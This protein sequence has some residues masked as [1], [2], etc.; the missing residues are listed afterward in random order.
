MY[1]ASCRY[2]ESTRGLR[3]SIRFA[4]SWTKEWLNSPLKLA[5][6]HVHASVRSCKVWCISSAIRFRFFRLCVTRGGCSILLECI[7]DSAS[8]TLLTHLA[9]LN[10]SRF[11]LLTSISSRS[12]RS[13]Y[14]IPFTILRY[15]FHSF[16]NLS[17][18][19]YYKVVSEWCTFYDSQSP[20]P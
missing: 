13:V 6:A 17:K 7:L 1:A 9:R 15:K 12:S 14:I 2:P 4:T 10:F 11:S 3:G 8:R 16:I 18:F 5:E 19:H 20:K